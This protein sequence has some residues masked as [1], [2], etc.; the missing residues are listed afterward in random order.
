MK[1]MVSIQKE[2]DQN[3]IYTKA[4]DKL[5]QDDYD[6]FLPIAK[7]IIKQHGKIRWYFEMNDFEGWTPEALWADIKFDLEHVDNFEKI[8]IVGRKEWM[9]WMAQLMKPFTSAEIKFF[10]LENRKQAKAWIQA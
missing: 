5:D 4:E 7:E 8:A 10:E 9:N 2:A 6:R 3:I 1:I